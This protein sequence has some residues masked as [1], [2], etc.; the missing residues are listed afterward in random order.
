MTLAVPLPDIEHRGRLVR[1]EPLAKHSS[2]RTGGAAEYFFEPADIDDLIAVLAQF[3]ESPI[4][5]LG[6][7]SNVLIREGGIEG[8]VI[9]TTKGLNMLRWNDENSLELGCGVA[10]AKVAKESV[11]KGFV[12]AEFLA[13][14]PGSIGGALA[15]NAGAF[16]GETWDLVASAYVVN[17]HG[18]VSRVVPG[19]YVTGYRH[20][21]LPQ[22]H[23]FISVVLEFSERIDLADGDGQ[24]RIK[25]L[26]S[27]RAALQPT[28]VASC[29]SVFKNP[30]DDYAG[31]LI[32]AAGLK[33]YQFGACAVSDKHANFIVNEHGA[34]ASEIEQLIKYIQSTVLEQFG[35]LLEPEVRIIG[36]ETPGV[37]Q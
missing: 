11:S 27:E 4:T 21:G 22:D 8:L 25:A 23:W 37:E 18:E 16:G 35:V 13:G 5:W 20:V 31:R 3:P 26:L 24:Q 28:G 9:S 15:M 6:L 32:E 7:G 30:T 14:I 33:G 34:R 1:D 17:R 29:G 12:G 2:W 10:C 36:R 19:D